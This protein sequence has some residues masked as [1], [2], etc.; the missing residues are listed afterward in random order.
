M[1]SGFGLCIREER[2]IDEWSGGVQAA[3]GVTRLMFFV[4]NDPS[5]G[6]ELVFMVTVYN[7]VLEI[8]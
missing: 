6:L 8:C 7:L 4:G 3:V 5:W 1:R 2:G